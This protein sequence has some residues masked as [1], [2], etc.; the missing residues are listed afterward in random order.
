[1]TDTFIKNT[2]VA[3]TPTIRG[4]LTYENKVIEKIVGLAVAHIDG[5]LAVSGGYLANIK[6]KLVNTDTV[7]EGV[8]VEVG[9]KQ[10]AVDLDIIAEYQK[11]VPTIFDDIK[12]TIE[13]EVKKM[14]DLDVIEVNVNVVDIKTKAQH[15]ADTV[16][17]Q[18]KVADAAHATSEFTSKQVGNVKSTVNENMQTE[19]RVK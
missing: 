19:P 8:S 18:D 4:E 11:H 12:K 3:D 1:M 17:L 10:V 14:T 13:T 9:K 5:L 2:Q 7:R 6:N 16:S 15:E